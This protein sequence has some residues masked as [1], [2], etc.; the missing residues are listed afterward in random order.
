MPTF[1]DLFLNDSLDLQNGAY[2]AF[3]GTGSANGVE[4]SANLSTSSY[5]LN[6]PI[7]QGAANTTF[8]NNGA[9]VLSFALISNANITSAAA[10]AVN[11]L[12]ALTVSSPVRSDSSGFLTTGAINLSTSDVTGN[13]PITNLN[14]GTSASSSTFWRGDGTWASPSGSG[15]VNSGT[16][17]QIAYYASSTNAVSSLPAITTNGTLGCYN[18]AGRGRN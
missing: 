15:T 9:G 4:V 2:I 3:K 6:W 8:I 11:K 17:G 13:L 14:S 1:F 18:W 12:A 7:N 5:I 16:S 10:I